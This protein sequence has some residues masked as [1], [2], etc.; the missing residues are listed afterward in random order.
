MC[1][2]EF[3]TK[4]RRTFHWEIANL[5]KKCL[6][7]TLALA[8]FLGMR[9]FPFFVPFTTKNA[10]IHSHV[11]PECHYFSVTNYHVYMLA[12]KKLQAFTL[13][14]GRTKTILLSTSGETKNR[15]F[16]RSVF[17]LFIP[18]FFIQASETSAS[19]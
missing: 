15:A 18:H 4:T 6:R 3:E 7:G 13:L 1:Q 5:V 17:S 11:D 9:V 10:H 12:F 2:F 19:P 8:V 16:F 14:Y